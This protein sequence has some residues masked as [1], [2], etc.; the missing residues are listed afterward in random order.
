MLGEPDNKGLIARAV[1]KYFA[2]KRELEALSRGEANISI[3]VELVEVYNED[4]R[5]LLS[6]SAVARSKSLKISNNEVVGNIVVQTDTENEVMEV[7]NLA[8]QRRCVKAT[9]S[10]SE[11]SR[12]HMLFTLHF[13]AS[14]P[15]GIQRAGK[16]NVCDLA[17][18]ERLG[19]S[20]ANAV[21]GVS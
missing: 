9:Q 1:E 3:S 4:V 20:G 17:G 21:V 16:L 5:D 18:S 7:L 11:S 8:Q 6:A 15:G 12:S 19:K 10:N 2:N 13:H 14:L